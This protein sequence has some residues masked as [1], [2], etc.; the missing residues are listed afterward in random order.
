MSGKGR[1]VSEN[2]LMYIELH[3]RGLSIPEIME[4]TGAPRNK[5]YSALRRAQDRG[6]VMISS[7]KLSYAPDALRQRFNLRMGNVS[8]IIGALNDEQIDWVYAEALKVGCETIAEY[9]TEVIRDL[10]ADSTL[11][12]K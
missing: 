9:L 1:A 11:G 7:T 4:R 2:S 8:T 3:Q 10:H 6:E 5:I 12:S